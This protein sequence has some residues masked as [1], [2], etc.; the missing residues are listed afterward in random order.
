MLTTILQIYL[1]NPV[2]ISL[3]IYGGWP[4]DEPSAQWAG[5]IWL[6]IAEGTAPHG[7]ASKRFLSDAPI[8]S[9]R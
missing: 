2:S 6:C 7:V 4:K 3:S 8:W 9:E 5:S 1:R